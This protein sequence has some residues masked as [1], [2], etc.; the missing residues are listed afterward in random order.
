MWYQGWDADTNTPDGEI[1][2]ATSPNGINWVKD[3]LNNPVLEV[4]PSGSFYDTWVFPSAVLLM[5]DTLRMWFTGWDGSL[6]G[7]YP[8]TEEIGYAFSSDGVNWVIE[9]NAQ[10]V[11]NVGAIGSWEQDQVICG[12]VLVHED[13]L[14]MFYVGHKYPNGYQIG[15]AIDTVFNKDIGINELQQS[16]ALYMIISPNPINDVATIAFYLSK[17]SN[18]SMVI[19]NQHGQVVATLLDEKTQ[20]GNH[21]LTYDTSA[22]PAG[23]YFCVL[24]SNNSMLTKKFIKM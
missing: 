6:Q 11:L 7:N 13:T 22:L 1:G 18:T 8:K 14:K 15:L 4:G 3:T 16:I 24:K 21:E 10:P 23:L 20:T 17:A 5:N 19:Y 12:S 9:N 2:Y